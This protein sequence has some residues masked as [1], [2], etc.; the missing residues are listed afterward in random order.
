MARNAEDAR[1]EFAD[2]SGEWFIADEAGVSRLKLEV[3]KRA[4][5][6]LY[7]RKGEDFGAVI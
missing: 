4:K 2:F 6:Y 1:L 7:L 5:E 3:R